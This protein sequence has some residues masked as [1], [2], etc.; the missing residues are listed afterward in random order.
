MKIIEFFKNLLNSLLD[1]SF[2]RVRI[3]KSMNEAFHEYYRRGTDICNR[4]RVG[5]GAR[6][7]FAGITSDCSHCSIAC[8]QEIPFLRARF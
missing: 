4:Q 1:G 3:I 6:G 7:A 8:L 2:E 5:G